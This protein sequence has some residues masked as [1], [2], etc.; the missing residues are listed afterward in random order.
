MRAYLIDPELRT[1]TE[2]N[3]VDDNYKRIQQAIGCKSFTTGS[4]PL[5]GSLSKGFDAIYVS[6]DMLDDEDDPQHWFQVDAD[7]DPPSSY[8][9]AG[10]GLVL[11]TDTEGVG[12]DVTISLEE[13]TPR[14]TFTRRKFRGTEF[15]EIPGGFSLTMRAPIIE[16][17][18]EPE[19]API[20]PI[21]L[22]AQRPESWNAKMPISG[23]PL[24]TDQQFKRL[25]TNAQQCVPLA[26]GL[27]PAPNLEPVVK[28]FLPHIRFFLVALD[29]DDL[30]TVFTVVDRG[31][32][33]VTAG[34]VSLSDIVGARLGA[35]KPERDMY[36]KL[37]KPWTWYLQHG[38]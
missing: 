34:K 21:A 14:I 28:I 31:P 8:P 19:G 13:L 9:I 11:G 37:N 25:L 10:K 23:K 22:P 18:S 16:D 32:N 6:D 24:I 3:L 20:Q 33:G 36:T 35:M 17:G 29:N 30:D 7:R 12:C 5:V 15:E 2:I 38:D 1:V 4:R 27:E 26:T